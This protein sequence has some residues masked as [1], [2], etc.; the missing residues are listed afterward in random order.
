MIGKRGW[1]TKD[2][3]VIKLSPYFKEQERI[4]VHNHLPHPFVK[5]KNLSLTSLREMAG[6]IKSSLTQRLQWRSKVMRHG[7][8][9][10]HPLSHFWFWHFEEWHFQ[11]CHFQI[12]S[13]MIIWIILT[14]LEKIL[15]LTLS[16]M[17]LSKMTLLKVYELIDIFISTFLKL[18]VDLDWPSWVKIFI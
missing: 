12:F 16:R 11:K 10:G 14:L 1:F 6:V 5:H 18:G 7:L 3:E 2:P 8:G 4:L 15:I 13:E 9:S 17:T